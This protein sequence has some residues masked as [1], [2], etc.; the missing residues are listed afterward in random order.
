MFGFFRKKSKPAETVQY[1]TPT[2]E[3]AKAE[4]KLSH[5]MACESGLALAYWLAAER[6]AGDEIMDLYEEYGKLAAEEH[7]TR[8]DDLE[9]MH[10]EH[11][12]S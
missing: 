3:A 4:L 8:H 7:G 2:V 9:A 1:A 11:A 12:Q 5:R 10:G 6:A